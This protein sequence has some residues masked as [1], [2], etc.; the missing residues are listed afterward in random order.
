MTATAAAL[1]LRA[2]NAVGQRGL[3]PANR[4]RFTPA[5]LA[6]EAARRGED[7]LA[8]LVDGWYYP[9]SYGHIRGALSYEE[10]N[11]LVAALEADLAR[12]ETAL[13]TAEHPP[14]FRVP[15]CVLCGFPV[16]PTLHEKG[17]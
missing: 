12:A 16:P 7:R 3:L 11:R 1:W 8:R 17:S 2:L 13:P 4:S 5:E 6:A 15:R 10:A 14:A 9:T